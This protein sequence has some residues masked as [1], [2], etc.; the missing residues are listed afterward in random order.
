MSAKAAC[1]L[2]VGQYAQGMTPKSD[3]ERAL[4]VHGDCGVT[5]TSFD[6]GESLHPELSV[7]EDLGVLN[8]K[9]DIKPVLQR[10]L[11]AAHAWV[12][13]AKILQPDAMDVPGV[14]NRVWAGNTG[15]YVTAL[16]FSEEPEGPWPLDVTKCFCRVVTPRGCRNC[17]PGCCAPAACKCKIGTFANAAALVL[18]TDTHCGGARFS[19]EDP[20]GSALAQPAEELA[21]FLGCANRDPSKAIGKVPESTIRCVL[22]A[23]NGKQPPT[24]GTVWTQLNPAELAHVK[25]LA[26]IKIAFFPAFADRDQPG[27]KKIVLTPRHES[28]YVLDG[29][30][31]NC[32]GVHAVETDSGLLLAPHRD[33]SHRGRRLPNITSVV[34]L[35]AVC[36]NDGLP[37]QYVRIAV[38]V[39]I[40]S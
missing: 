9:A 6:T 15:R 5:V 12:E 24:T 20:G 31:G 13:S 30:W 32:A 26:P 4:H 8:E 23:V 25:G 16:P 11:A 37:P 17:D 33:A 28:I 3:S 19:S 34:T 2:Y 21:R 10:T 14:T 27:G 18:K 7:G 38:I 29:Y 40:Y 39:W 35:Y 1:A 22:Y 36:E